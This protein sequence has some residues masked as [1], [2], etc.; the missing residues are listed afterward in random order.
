MVLVFLIT[1]NKTD[2]WC[3][4][5]GGECIVV[6]VGNKCD[7]NEKR[8]VTVEEGKEFAQK[9]EIFFMETSALASVNIDQVFNVLLDHMKNDSAMYYPELQSNS[10][11]LLG[12]SAP[13]AGMALTNTQSKSCCG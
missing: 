10:V 4:T 13:L 12:S 9:N 7:L 5:E 8:A 2:G 11:N 3:Y 6:L 1:K